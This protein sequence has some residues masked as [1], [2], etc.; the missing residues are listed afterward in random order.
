MKL[1]LYNPVLIGLRYSKLL[2]RS[3]IRTDSFPDLLRSPQ[4]VR[5]ATE[6]VSGRIFLLS[7]GLYEF[8]VQLFRVSCVRRRLLGFFDFDRD[9]V[10]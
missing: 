6:V 3:A 7:C 9:K 1:S 5:V 10:S 4:I 8:T 2:W